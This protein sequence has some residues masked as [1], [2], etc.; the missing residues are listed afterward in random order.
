MKKRLPSPRRVSA[1]LRKELHAT[2]A[3]PLLYVVGGVF[4]LLAGYY[5]YS[6]LGFFVTFGFGQN[7]FEN[8]FQLLF[9]DLRLVLL[10]TVPLLTMRLFAEERKLGTIELLFTYPLSDLEI[11]LAKLIA[12]TLA[13]CALLLTTAVSL[14]YLYRIEPFAF[15]PVFTG[16]LGLALLAV[17]FVA[18]GTFL[19]T[20]TD[21]Q[22]VAAMS[23][24][25]TLLLLWIL[26]WNEAAPGIASLGFFSR[27]SIFN[28]FE[29]FSRGVI[30]TKDLV[31]FACLVAFAAAATLAS[32]G[33]RAWPRSRLAPTVVGLLG[34]LVALGIVDAFAERHNMRF[35]LTPQQK[36]TL[37]PHARRILDSVTQPI[38]LI[39]FVRS[40][41]PRNA[42]TVDLLERIS[43][44]T[45][46][47]KHRVVDVNRNPALARRYGVDAFGAIVIA[48]E[49]QHRVVGQ[50]REHMVVGAIL[51]LTRGKRK[52]VGFVGGHGEM[53]PGDRDRQ[54][55]LS[56]LASSLRDDGF[57]VRSVTIADGVP[58]DVDVLVVAGG[59]SPWSDAELARLDEWMAQ[60]GRLLALLDP[61]QAP[62]LAAWLAQR[63]IAPAPNVVLDP[64]NRLYGGEGVSIEAAPPADIAVLD[65]DGLPSATVIASELGQGVLLSTA[66]ALELSA[67]AVPLLQSGAESW[68]T[69]AIERA[70]SG[71]VEYEEGRD[72]P[73]PQVVAAAREW[74][75]AGDDDEASVARLVVIGDVDLATN[76]FIEFLSN[77]HVLHNAITWLVGE[78][79]LIAMRPERK[80]SGREQLFLSAGQARTA[81]LLSTGVMPGLSLLVALVLYLRRRTGA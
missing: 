73:G 53:D 37:S 28:H 29:S 5:F 81:L 27:L 3:Q 56:L 20:L 24:V 18:C 36:Y 30:E 10:L 38:E 4:L 22:V 80:Q 72:V 32:L 76:R 19:S 57:D 21:N 66:R 60:G 70:E 13:A 65:A 40:G 79:A 58:D 77:R 55:G 54:R 7:I 23:T 59:E 1:L 2:F 9:V 14:V 68:A 12:C 39:A 69:T 25:G 45:P 6:D 34:L 42:S 16:Y 67:G 17:S 41:D 52:V 75:V 15:G 71:D 43:E 63:G 47:I 48:T 74:Q 46:L 51:Q 33:S 62:E 8:F 78:E 44:V 64:E 26:S 61:R 35:D 50:A 11:L 31:Y 49:D